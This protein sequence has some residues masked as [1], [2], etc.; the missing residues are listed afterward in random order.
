VL[1]YLVAFVCFTAAFAISYAHG[2]APP[3]SLEAPFNSGVWVYRITQ[4]EEHVKDLRNAVETINK[5][6]VG[7]LVALVINL[8][9]TLVQRRRVTVPGEPDQHRD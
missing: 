6:I 5:L 9:L 3:A 8:I 2:Q 1:L 4:M 7:A